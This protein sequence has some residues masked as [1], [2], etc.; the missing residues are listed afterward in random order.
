VRK[1]A[2]W[3]GQR[4]VAGKGALPPNDQEASGNNE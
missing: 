4:F 2:L 1:Q 3:S